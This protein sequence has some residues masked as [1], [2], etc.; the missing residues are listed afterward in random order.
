MRIWSIVALALGLFILP[1]VA[2]DLPVSNA[3]YSAQRV[4][5]T[6]GAQIMSGPVYHDRGKERW[7]V[8]K[9]GMPQVM[10]MRPDLGKLIMYMPRMNMGMEL[11]LDGDPRFGLPADHAGPKPKA[12]GR[13]DVAGE[14]TTK[15][16]TEIDNG[17][18]APF[19]VSSW[20]T[21]DGIIMRIE[22][23]G[24]EGEFVMYLKGLSRGPQDAALFEMPAG[25]QLMPTNP[26]L[27]SQPK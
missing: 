18:D 9:G 12:V 15:Y 5:E 20:V 17:T 25:A 6:A 26:A 13:E 7:E 11:A 24:P 1:A 16:R 10:I 4:M 3:A 14:S 21:D 22:G 23:R 27:L 19:I 8:S 2:A